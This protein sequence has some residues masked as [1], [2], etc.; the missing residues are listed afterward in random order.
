M[1][2]L[3]PC[4][5]ATSLPKRTEHMVAGWAVTP[6]GNGDIRRLS[7]NPGFP[8]SQLCD[9]STSFLKAFTVAGN[10]IYNLFKRDLQSTAWICWFTLFREMSLGHLAASRGI[11]GCHIWWE[12]CWWEGEE[13]KNRLNHLSAW[14]RERERMRGTPLITS[15][16]RPLQTKLQ[17]L[18][19]LHLKGDTY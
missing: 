12:W 2:W 15:Q 9:Q 11:F 3:G 4:G 8:G 16:Q 7:L 17:R 5:F 6:A 1:V 14:N 18:R 19:S 13:T 10:L